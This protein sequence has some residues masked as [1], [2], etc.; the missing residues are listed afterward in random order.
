[1]SILAKNQSSISWRKRLPACDR[2]LI[3]S[4]ICPNLVS[5]PQTTNRSKHFENLF[6]FQEHLLIQVIKKEN[7]KISIWI[8]CYKNFGE[9][10]FWRDVLMAKDY[11][12]KKQFQFFVMF[13]IVF[14]FDFFKSF[15]VCFQLVCAFN[16]C[17]FL[18]EGVHLT[19][20][21]LLAI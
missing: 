11:S 13:L 15:L 18:G 12:P 14:S 16:V 20:N 4:P 6:H 9:H 5:Q 21:L 10:K 7:S 2:F 17:S 8:Y 1:M 19:V 3:P